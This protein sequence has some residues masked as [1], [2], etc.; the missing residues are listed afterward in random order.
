MNET[1]A[2]SLAQQARNLGLDA[3]TVEEADAESLRIFARAVLVELAA[4]GLVPGEESLGC[5]ARPRAKGH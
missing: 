1:F 5:W 2:R 3:L 4:L